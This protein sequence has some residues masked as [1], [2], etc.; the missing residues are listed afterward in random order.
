MSVS[1]CLNHF[2]VLSDV[3]A[4]LQKWNTFSVWKGTVNKCIIMQIVCNS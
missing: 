2:L 4:G 1:V 3:F